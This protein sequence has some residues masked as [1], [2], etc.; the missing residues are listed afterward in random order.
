MPAT[1]IAPTGARRNLIP[2]S[3]KLRSAGHAVQFVAL[4]RSSGEALC[5]AL[6]LPD[7][8]PPISGSVKPVG[9]SADA[10]RTYRLKTA[11]AVLVE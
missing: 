1:T 8:L 7:L 5:N 11:L 4:A 6:A 3:V 10:L 9:T 2:F